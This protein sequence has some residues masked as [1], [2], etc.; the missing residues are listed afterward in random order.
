MGSLIFIRLLQ[1]PLILA[2][3]F[4]VTFFLLWELPGNPLEQPD[5]RRPPAAVEQA[6][7]E[8]YNLDSRT[9]FLT[10]YFHRLF[11]QGDFGPSLS[12]PGVSVN[13]YISSG[14]P[15]SI[16][17]GGV[18]LGFA[19]L[20]GTTGGIISS[21]RPGSALDGASM[22]LTLIGISLPSFVTGSVLL[23]LFAGYFQWA[24]P[25]GWIEQWPS[26]AFWHD[27][28]WSEYAAAGWLLEDIQ[29]VAKRIILPGI[30]LS[31]IPAAYIARLIKLGLADVMNSDFV[32]TARAKG[33]SRSK[34]LF[35]HALKVAYLPVIS[36]LGP[37]AASTMTGSFVVEK[38]FNLPGMGD[39]FVNGVLNKDITLVMA[40]VLMYSTMLI[41]FNLIVDVAYAW[42]DPRI[43]L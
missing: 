7:K 32:R 10:S 25:G 24:D 34:A 17:L 28:W 27:G 5:S 1:L 33:L 19:V 35:K 6:M 8:Q 2:I 37:A 30:A 13:D 43:E 31:L 21:L 11:T 41:V 18:A 38:V 9:S 14:M 15:V 12:R 26:F 22:L 39:H 4:F 42:V 3:I 16:T 20:I 29:H 36:Y 40:V 23:I